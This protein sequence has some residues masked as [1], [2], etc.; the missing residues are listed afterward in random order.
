MQ[1]YFNPTRRVMEDN[2]NV[3]LKI[4]DDLNFVQ[5]ED[6]RNFFLKMEDDL[7]VVQMEENR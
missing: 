2:H 1:P 4:E 5:M 3:F 6:N 7:N